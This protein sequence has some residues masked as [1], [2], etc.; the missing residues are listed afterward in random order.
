MNSDN[1]SIDAVS[2]AVSPV[3]SVEGRLRSE[4]QSVARSLN[5]QRLRMGE[6]LAKVLRTGCFKSWG[7]DS[8]HSYI[9][10]EC[11]LSVRS[12]QSLI[13]IFEVFVGQLNMEQ[14]DIET[15]GWS[16]AQLIA[17]RVQ[18]AIENGEDIEPLLTAAKTQPLRRLR[19][20][21]KKITTHPITNGK[22]VASAVLNPPTNNGASIVSSVS[23]DDEDAR[24]A[25]LQALSAAILK[26][27]TR[28]WPDR[29][30]D[31]VIRASD[32]RQ[33]CFSMAASRH[34]LILGPS[35][36]GKTEIAARS[37]AAFGRELHTF[38]FGAMSEPRT[39]LIGSIHFNPE[40]GTNFASSRFVRALQTRRAVILLDEINRCERDAYNILIPLLDG[41]R[42]IALDEHPDSPVVELAEEVCFFATANVGSEYVGAETLD[43]AIKDR[44]STVIPLWFAPLEDE[45]DLLLQRVCGLEPT[46]AIKLCQFANRQRELWREGEFTEVI[47]T[48]SLLAAAQQIPIGVSVDEAITYC[49]VNHFSDEGCEHSDRTK[50]RQLLQRHG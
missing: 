17:S 19:E 5:G 41:Q 2:P 16:K 39:S 13:K 4:I 14:D 9:E 3:A 24:L 28:R 45:V 40:T 25:V 22:P 18:A 32:W 44:F 7:Y 12:A 11:P 29:P 46:D 36:S 33:L 27:P 48:R 37:A 26:A 38:N 35:G 23:P 20:S 30:H 34:T 43:K 1:L 6:L 10:T 50:L 42:V 8:L 31:F 47:S 49:V 15:I 21:I